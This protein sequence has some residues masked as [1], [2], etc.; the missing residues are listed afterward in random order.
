LPIESG[1]QDL[2]FRHEHAIDFAQH[3]V[4]LVGELEYMR[5]HDQVDRLRRKRQLFEM[6]NHRRTWV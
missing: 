1:D 6:R 2:S 4:R 5:H 3:L